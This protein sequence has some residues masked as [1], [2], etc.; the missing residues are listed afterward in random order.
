MHL[1]MNLGHLFSSGV[2]YYFTSG[3]DPKIA[4]TVA[5]I[6][7]VVGGCVLMFF[8]SEPKNSELIKSSI[9]V[10]NSHVESF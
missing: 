3:H 10:K 8:I 9:N 2:L 5:A 1:G 6:Y 7:G 4:F